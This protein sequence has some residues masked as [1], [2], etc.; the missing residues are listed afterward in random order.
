M[1]EALCSAYG[2]STPTRML[3]TFPLE[4]GGGHPRWTGLGNSKQGK[5]GKGS[6]GVYPPFAKG[7]KRVSYKRKTGGGR[8]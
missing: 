3:L 1:A 2:R 8:G 6:W 5:V 7:R 4:G